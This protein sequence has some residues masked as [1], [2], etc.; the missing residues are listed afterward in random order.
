MEES[1]RVKR[2]GY[3]TLIQCPNHDIRRRGVPQFV[4]CSFSLDFWITASSSWAIDVTPSTVARFHAYGCKVSGRS[5]E[6]SLSRYWVVEWENQMMFAV[7]RG[8]SHWQSCSISMRFQ[9]KLA[10]VHRLGRDGV[11]CAKFLVKTVSPWTEI[12]CDMTRRVAGDIHLI[13]RVL[14]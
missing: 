11:W 14:A 5:F 7:G 4:S 2:L 1:D 3:R 8:I 9:V 13:T 12:N 10:L 6:N